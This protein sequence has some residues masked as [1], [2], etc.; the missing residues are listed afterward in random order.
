MIQE[1]NKDID[2]EV[3]THVCEFHKKFPGKDYAGCGCS[4]SYV[5]KKK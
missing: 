5:G 3:N 4:T 2:V 1:A